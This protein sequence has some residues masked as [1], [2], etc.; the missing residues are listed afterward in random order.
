MKHIKGYIGRRMSKNALKAHQ[1]NQFTISQ[2]NHD[3]LRTNGFEYSVQFFKWLCRKGYIRPVAYHHTGAAPRMTNFYSPETIIYVA[4][5]YNLSMLYKLYLGRMSKMD[6]YGLLGIQYVRIRVS[7]TLLNEDA[8]MVEV[9]VVRYKNYYFISKNQWIHLRE[10]EV[11]VL[12]QWDYAPIGGVW[13]NKNRKSI[14]RRI[15]LFRDIN[16]IL[17]A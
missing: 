13:R 4:E 12:K 10:D 17:T 15:L 3:L 14:V 8:Q 5:K 7:G 11:E 6:L 2:V 1:K 9:D 16:D